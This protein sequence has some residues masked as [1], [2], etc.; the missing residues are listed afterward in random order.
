MDIW[1]PQGI[2]ECIPLFLE[3]ERKVFVHES[4]EIGPE[5]TIRPNVIIAPG[6]K[7]GAA[8]CIQLSWQGRRW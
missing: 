5:C 8:C 3:G 1:T 7:I 6:V 4:A 2:L